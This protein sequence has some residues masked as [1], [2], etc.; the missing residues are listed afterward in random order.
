[1]KG[2]MRDLTA[3]KSCGC[4]PKDATSRMGEELTSETSSACLS[5][6]NSGISLA[7]DMMCSWID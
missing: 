2:M 7:F 1:M 6:S 3:S 5:G 4:Q